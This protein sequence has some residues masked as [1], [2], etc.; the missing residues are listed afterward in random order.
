M[1][2]P[3][4]FIALIAAAPAAVAGSQG[5]VHRID[6]ASGQSKGLRPEPGEGEAALRFHWNAPLIGSRHAKGTMY[7]AGNR[8]FR[9]TLFTRRPKG[10]RQPCELSHFVITHT[11][12]GR[13]SAGRPG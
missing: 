12:S 13:A 8:V 10:A 9:G 3:A 4:T 2:L 1:L 5:F 6:L 7:L 11:V